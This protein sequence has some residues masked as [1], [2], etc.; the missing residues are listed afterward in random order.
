MLKYFTTLK[1]DEIYSLALGG[2]DGMHKAH[3]ELERRIQKDGV[4]FVIDK[5][6]ASLTPGTFRCQYTKN[7]CVFVNLDDIKDLNANQFV[8]F[9]KKEFCNLKK[10]VVGYDFRFGKNKEANGDF[11][12]KFF[13]EVDIVKEIK[14]NNISVHSKKIRE[15]LKKGN[16]KLANSLLARDYNVVGQ[17]IKGQGIGKKKLFATLNLSTNFFLPKDGVYVV[18]VEINKIKYKGV[19]FIGKRVS[20]DNNFAFEVHLIDTFLENTP[21]QIEVFF[22][23]FI[24]ENKKFTSLALLK[25]QI[26]SDIDVANKFFDD[27]ENIG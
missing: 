6:Y 11:L 13:E 1:K 26:Q 24:R 10:I 7:G 8:L 12:K 5:G 18:A 15:L 20:L 16:I 4:L 14:V 19:A 23:D 22:K 2:F 9:L 21:K 27:I 3:L 17:V 25:K